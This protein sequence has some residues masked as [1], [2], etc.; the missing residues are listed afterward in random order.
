MTAVLT[1]NDLDSGYSKGRPV[2]RGFDLELN[3]GQVLALLGPNGS[4]KTTVLMTMAGL[5]PSLGG[6]IRIGD[7]ELKPGHARNAS[8]A[9]LVL[10]PDDRS[11]FTSLT[12]EEN[13]RLAFRHAV[14]GPVNAPG[15]SRTSPRWLNG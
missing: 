6:I 15:S 11:L 7:Q 10:V 12:T 5:L 3:A 13:L 2:V 1:C 8:R 14:R 9:G 4:G